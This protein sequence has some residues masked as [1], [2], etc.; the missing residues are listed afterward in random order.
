MREQRAASPA[1]ESAVSVTVTLFVDRN[2]LVCW[3]RR[4]WK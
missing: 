1:S 4:L 2:A 3:C